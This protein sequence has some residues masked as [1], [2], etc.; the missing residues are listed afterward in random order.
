[1]YDDTYIYFGFDVTDT[2]LWAVGLAEVDGLHLD[3]GVE[4]FLNND[5]L[6]AQTS[7]NNKYL[8]K[9]SCDSAVKQSYII[10]EIY[11]I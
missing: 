7:V 8:A 10:N 1:M 3:D 5:Q 9:M 2:D 6:Y 4:I 11:S